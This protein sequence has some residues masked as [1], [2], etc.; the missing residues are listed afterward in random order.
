VAVADPRQRRLSGVLIVVETALAVA[1]L[2]GSG[3][4][5]RTF[6]NLTRE[7]PGF[8]TERAI[9]V[10]LSLPLSQRR[11]YENMAAYFDE[12]IR[13]IRALPGVESVGGATYL[14][15]IGYNPGVNF[16]LDGRASSPDTAP[17]ADIQPITPDYFQAIGIPMLRGR[18]FTEAEMAPQPNTALVNNVFANKYWPAED[19]LGK[20]IL[21]QDDALSRAPLVVVGVVGDVKQFGVRTGSRPEIYIPLRQPSMTLVVRTTGNAARLFASVRDAVQQLDDQAAVSMRTMEDVLSRAN[22]T[23][24][25]LAIRLAA[26]SAAAL[27]MAGMGIYGVIS[28]VVA[29]RTRELGIRLALGAHRR[30][31]LRLVLRQGMKLTLVGVAIGLALS[32]AL[33]RFIST[34]LFGVSA[35]DPLTFTA[36]TLLLLC[37]ALIASYRPARRATKVDPLIALKYE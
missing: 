16:T 33:S 28:Y 4:M 22:W 34:Q 7:D 26:L 29:Q 13:R 36:I 18:Q 14:P 6:L 30:D 1:L 5:I 20:Q 9:A 8:K 25:N 32:L 10:S 35:Y 24:R 11:D 17:R 21:L 19:P 15:L 27:L 37:V 12:A 3:L 2:T 31:I 23:P